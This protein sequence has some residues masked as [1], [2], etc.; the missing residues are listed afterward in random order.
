MCEWNDVPNVCVCVCLDLDAR[1]PRLN[2]PSPPIPINKQQAAEKRYWQCCST[3]QNV[4]QPYK[5]LQ[6]ADMSLGVNLLLF[7][8]TGWETYGAAITAHMDNWIKARL[9]CLI[10]PPPFCRP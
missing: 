6:W 5:L 10:F 1:L 9:C 3:A 2:P 7:E 8:L 4:Q